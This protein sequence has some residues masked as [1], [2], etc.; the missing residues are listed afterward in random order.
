M[1]QE[2]LAQA[3]KVTK[4]TISKWE[5]GARIPD[6]ATI[7]KLSAVLDAAPAYILGSI[8]NRHGNSDERSESA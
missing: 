1:R 5:C 4:G 2:D 3:I 7:Q 6:Y 8:D